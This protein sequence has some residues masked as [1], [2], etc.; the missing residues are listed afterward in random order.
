MLPPDSSPISARNSA[1]NL[2]EQSPEPESE[3]DLN[4]T[5]SV[6]EDYPGL[7][8]RSLTNS[9]SSQSDMGSRIYL[10][11]AA[12]TN[13]SRPS[14]HSSKVSTPLQSR[15]PAPPRDVIETNTSPAKNSP[16]LAQQTIGHDH[17][18][19]V[20]GQSGLNFQVSICYSSIGSPLPTDVG[21]VG[22]R[23]ITWS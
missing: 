9:I 17:S 14:H 12:K 19:V 4:S 23:P 11:R 22:G 5:T 2:K 8:P 3:H 20:S 15:S 10:P 16:G 7:K 13:S 18:P 6:E 1:S 21:K